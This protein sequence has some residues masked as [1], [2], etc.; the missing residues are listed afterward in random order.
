MKFPGLK[1]H[2]HIS[3]ECLQCSQDEHTP[4]LYCS[5]NNMDPDPVPPL[6]ANTCSYC[7]LDEVTVALKY[8]FCIH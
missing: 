4:K 8:Q 6:Q 5:T 2:S 3:I 1:I 7:I